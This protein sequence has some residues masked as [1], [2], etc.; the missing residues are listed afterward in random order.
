MSPF[1]RRM[2]IDYITAATDGHHMYNIGHRGPANWIVIC[3][4]K[5]SL[6]YAAGR[7]DERPELSTTEETQLRHASRST[8]T[9]NQL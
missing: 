3:F 4:E 2:N 1:A 9:H 8:H 6:V 7:F 5:V